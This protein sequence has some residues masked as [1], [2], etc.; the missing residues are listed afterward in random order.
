MIQKIDIVLIP[1]KH[2]M[3][4]GDSLWSILNNFAPFVNIEKAIRSLFG[5]SE[6]MVAVIDKK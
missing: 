6:H 5:W 2:L 1:S 4:F 3:T